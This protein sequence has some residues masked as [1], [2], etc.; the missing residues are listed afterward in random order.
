MTLLEKI[1][2]KKIAAELALRN[3]P[4]V[5]MRTDFEKAVEMSSKNIDGLIEEIAETQLDLRIGIE[6]TMEDYHKLEH[7]MNMKNLPKIPGQKIEELMHVWREQDLHNSKALSK[8]ENRQYAVELCLSLEEY[9]EQIRKE[10][11]GYELAAVHNKKKH[12]NQMKSLHF[13]A[14]FYIEAMESAVIES[15]MC[16]M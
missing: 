8:E 16:M 13:K 1:K 3:R 2:L 4:K 11:K 14:A 12:T 9:E 5:D 7:E 6:D 10:T 15:R